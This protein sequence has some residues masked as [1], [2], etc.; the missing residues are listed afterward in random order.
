MVSRRRP[1]G[2]SPRTQR[3]GGRVV[4][5]GFAAFSFGNPDHR[6]ALFGVTNRGISTTNSGPGRLLENINE[7]VFERGGPTRQ[8][9]NAPLFFLHKGKKILTHIHKRVCCNRERDPAAS[10]MDNTH[11]FD[12]LDRLDR[13]L[14]RLNPPFE[15][16]DDRAGPAQAANEILRGIGR[17]NVTTIDNDDTAACH[18]NLGENVSGDKNGMALTKTLDEFSRLP[19]LIRIETVGGLIEDEQFRFVHKGIGETDALLIALRK[20]RDHLFLNSGEAADVHRFTYRPGRC[21]PPEPLDA[22]PETQILFDSHIGIERDILRHITNAATDLD[23]ILVDVVA[24]HRRRSLR[25]G[26]EAGQHA[27]SRAFSRP[28]RP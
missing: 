18:L 25:R 1:G 15:L 13:D 26:K 19:D 10:L 7:S 3:G 9:A 21:P 8:L 16:K 14:C 11:R 12:P 6:G 27:Q 22:G 17:T 23:G 24:C 28:V 2:F 5:V 4:T 20:S